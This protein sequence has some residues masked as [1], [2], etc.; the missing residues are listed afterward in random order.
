MTKTELR[1]IARQI[2]KTNLTIWQAIHEVEG[3]LK[4]EIHLM[5]EDDLEKLAKEII[6]LKNGTESMAEP[7]SYESYFQ[8][9]QY[10]GNRLQRYLD[11]YQMIN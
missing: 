11:K 9:F 3:F 7:Q 1:K 6:T 10:L 2:I 8:N 5:C 4:D